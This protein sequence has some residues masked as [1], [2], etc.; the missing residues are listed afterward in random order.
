VFSLA[1]NPDPP[2]LQDV[3]DVLGELASGGLLTGQD[4][5]GSYVPAPALLDLAQ[6]LD[7]IDG[8][9]DLERVDRTED[10][11]L[12]GRILHVMC[13]SAGAFLLE[14]TGA[15]RIHVQLADRA[16]TISTVAKILVGQLAATPSQA[17]ETVEVPLQAVVRN[18]F[19]THC[20]KPI[21]PSW[22]FCMACGT[23]IGGKGP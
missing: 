2:A 17:A 8:G 22:R 23:A 11:A 5:A 15:D 19:C 6:V 20:G 9:F 10:G 1:L 13:G 7:R 16:A 18:R 3:N 21:D 4:E 12:A 14:L